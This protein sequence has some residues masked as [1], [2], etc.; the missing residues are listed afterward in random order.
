MSVKRVP[1][2]CTRN[3]TTA[4]EVAAP[5]VSEAQVRWIISKTSCLNCKIY[6]KFHPLN[7]STLVLNP[8]AFNRAWPLAVHHR[9]ALLVPHELFTVFYLKLHTKYEKCSH[10]NTIIRIRE[11]KSECCLD[12]KNLYKQWNIFDEGIIFTLFLCYE[13]VFFIMAHDRSYSIQNL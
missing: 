3:I 9:W 11:R 6:Q 8:K 13:F 2:L 4:V 1:H 7:F 10:R 5:A 12:K